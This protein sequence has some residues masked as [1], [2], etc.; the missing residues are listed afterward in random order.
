M[1]GA[2]FALGPSSR[3][4]LISCTTSLTQSPRTQIR[5]IW[6]AKYAPS[7]YTLSGEGGGGGCDI[8]RGSNPG[9]G[10]VNTRDVGGGGGVV[11]MQMV[12]VAV[13]AA[14]PQVEV[15]WY[16]E[17]YPLARSSGWGPP[18]ARL[19]TSCARTCSVVLRVWL[20]RGGVW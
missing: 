13:V 20:V 2:Y 1:E 11:A 4:V 9:A 19:T 3:P 12:R 6:D 15:V 18:G 5:N 8:F 10:R 16:M 14:Q 7:T 17:P